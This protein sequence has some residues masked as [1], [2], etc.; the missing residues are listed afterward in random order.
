MPP[1]GVS[2]IESETWVEFGG[3][4]LPHQQFV[5]LTTPMTGML[6][7]QQTPWQLPFDWKVYGP[8][9]TMGAAV[10]KHP[11]GVMA[12]ILK[13]A[14]GLGMICATGS[15]TTCIEKSKHEAANAAVCDNETMM[16][17]CD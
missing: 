8:W 15:A 9:S 10:L 2:H 13:V 7:P 5:P 1:H 16:N 14:V 6:N 4:R 3:I 17:M 11:T 12:F